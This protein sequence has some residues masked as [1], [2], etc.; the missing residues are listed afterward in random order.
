[1]FSI[2]ASSKQKVYVGRLERV[3]RRMNR[4][5]GYLPPQEKLGEQGLF[6]PGKRRFRGAFITMLQFLKGSY[7][8]D[9][10]PFY[11]ESHGKCKR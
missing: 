7:R 5:L 8:E 10:T 4:E 2:S 1:M 3:Q 11:K 9:E 6:R